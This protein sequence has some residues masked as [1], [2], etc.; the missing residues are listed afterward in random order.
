[1][2]M[3]EELMQH[4]VVRLDEA[5][6]MLAGMSAR[7]LR[8]KMAEHGMQLVELGPRI[9]GCPAERHRRADR[10]IDPATGKGFMMDG[11]LSTT[12]SAAELDSRVERPRR[13]RL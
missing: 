11:D 9:R 10:G 8:A 6:E 13:G 3:T 4:R 1:M 5:A 7:T 2:T 12:T